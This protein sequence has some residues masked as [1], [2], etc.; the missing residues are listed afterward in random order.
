MSLTWFKNYL[1]WSRAYTHEQQSWI[2][3]DAQSFYANNQGEDPAPYAVVTAT[4]QGGSAALH[5][6]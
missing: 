1:L 6:A 2:K 4:E 5:P 3:H